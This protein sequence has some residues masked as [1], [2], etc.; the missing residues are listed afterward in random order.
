MEPH[1]V[2]KVKNVLSEKVERA[3]RLYSFYVGIDI[4]YKFHVAACI[5]HEELHDSKGLW[6]KK[7]TRKINADSDGIAGFLNFLREVGECNQISPKNFF[8]LLEPT[9]GNYGYIIMKALI[10][11]G[12]TLYQVKNKAV[13]DFRECSLGIKEKSDEIDARVMAYMGYYKSLNPALQSV[14]IITPYT[15]T[16]IL[17][18]ALTK[19]RW[20][21][22]QQLTRRKNQ[23][24]QL[25]AV[26]N[27]E[28]KSLFA[29]PTVPSVLRFALKYPT[30][31]EIKE[32]T[33]EELRRSLVASGAR[34]NAIKNAK[35]LVDAAQKSVVIQA[36]HLANRQKWLIDEVFR[37]HEAINQIDE[38]ISDLLF[39]NK[40]KNL[41]SHPYADILF[42]LPV[43]GNIWAS[44]LI[45]VIGDVHRFNNFR[46]FKKY[47]GVSAENAKSG[48]SIHKTRMTNEGV[49]DARRVLFQMSLVHISSRSAP[50][51]FGIQYR[52]LLEGERGLSTNDKNDSYW[53]YIRKNCSNHIRMSEIWKIILCSP[54]CECFKCNTR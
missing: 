8:I 35:K 14:S 34:A 54:S 10:D 44:T 3:N 16:Q 31:I 20:L 48:I 46:Q 38:H 26:T 27:P 29:K 1:K 15:P 45:G 47:L 18:R 21:L 19:D 30:M 42:S 41:P 6:K 9:G 40:E 12:Y 36:P 25:F 39:G 4:G 23:I 52:R 2:I 13:K 24:H 28:L 7:K 17:F 11:I 32:A 50:N 51:V 5:S 53:T 49:R 33:E 22:S 43:M 37:L